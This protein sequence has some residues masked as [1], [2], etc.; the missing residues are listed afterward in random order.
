[1]PCI[2]RRLLVISYSYKLF[3]NEN[4]S[5]LY[6]TICIIMII[7]YNSLIISTS[8]SYCLTYNHLSIVRRI[9]MRL[10]TWHGFCRLSIC[11]ILCLSIYLYQKIIT[12]S[13]YYDVLSGILYSRQW[14]SASY[15]YVLFRDGD[16]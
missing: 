2:I 10:R 1:M 15:W 3:Y 16:N 7:V 8:Y 14:N 13:A 11:L 5:I 6:T 4:M 9:I 12:L